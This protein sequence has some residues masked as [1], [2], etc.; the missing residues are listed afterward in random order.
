MLLATWI[1]GAAVLLVQASNHR[2]HHRRYRPEVNAS[3]SHR[4]ANYTW[5]RHIAERALPY[6]PL[7]R[8]IWVDMYHG[9]G[10]NLLAGQ[11]IL[12]WESRK[13]ALDHKYN[14]G[15]QG[16]DDWQ[17]P[18]F[19]TPMGQREEVVIRMAMEDPNFSYAAIIQ[20]DA[21]EEV[22]DEFDKRD[23]SSPNPNHRTDK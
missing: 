13:D 19:S 15:F 14:V 5:F 2:H 11:I 9:Y 18:P 21:S 23:G 7:Y 22:W 3:W 1:F 16:G 10:P 8:K 12:D 4:G 17:K 6:I 20:H